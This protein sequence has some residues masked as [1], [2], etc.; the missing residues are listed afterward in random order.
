M[1]P[2]PDSVY[3][4]LPMDKMNS[5]ATFSVTPVFF[6]I[7]INENA[8]IAGRLGQNGPQEKNNADNF[9]VVAEYYRR[10]RKLGLQTCGAKSN[11][12]N[13]KFQ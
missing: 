13:R 12:G 1:L 3:A 6:N 5:S 10:F 8:T 9:K 4:M 2:V 7:G 11:S